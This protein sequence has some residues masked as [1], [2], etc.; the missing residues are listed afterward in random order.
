MDLDKSRNGVFHV[1]GS[2]NELV[3]YNQGKLFIFKTFVE[4]AGTVALLCAGTSILA[5]KGLLE[6][7]VRSPLAIHG[8][9]TRVRR[10]PVAARVVENGKFITP[11]GVCAGVDMALYIVG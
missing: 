2:D 10:A 1:V 3:S 6:N 9:V 7:R 4:R 11:G 5:S 8:S